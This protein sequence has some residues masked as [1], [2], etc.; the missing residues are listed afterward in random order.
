MSKTIEILKEYQVNLNLA[1][2][3]NASRT[4]GDDFEKAKDMV[5]ELI[6]SGL[7]THRHWHTLGIVQA[8]LVMT[9][10]YSSLMIRHHIHAIMVEQDAKHPTVYEIMG[11]NGRHE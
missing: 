5:D 7:V 2:V 1:V 4:Y 6:V 9:D 8:T 11:R 3:N 10:L